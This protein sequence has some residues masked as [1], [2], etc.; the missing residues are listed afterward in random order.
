MKKTMVTPLGA[1]V[2]F[3][4]VL[5]QTN[6]SGPWEIAASPNLSLATQVVLYEN[7]PGLGVFKGLNG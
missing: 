5:V 7:C 3:Y 1:C 6:V 2:R 4:P